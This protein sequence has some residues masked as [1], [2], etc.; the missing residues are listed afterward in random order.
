[1]FMR[2]I[3]DEWLAQG[4]Y[5]IGCQRTGEAIVID[6]ERDVDRYINLAAEHDLR[7][8]AVAETHIHADFLSGARELAEQVGARVYVSA[9]GG[10]DWRSGWLG[11][12]IDGGA[13]DAVELEDGQTF[14]IG[15]IE[16]RAVHT[17]G[18][19]PEHMSY[20]VTDLG[21]GASE[22]MGIATG[23]FVFV[24]DL[25]RPDLLETAA[26]HAGAKEPAARELAAS[27]RQFVK[28]PDYLQVWPAHGSGSACGKALGAVP[29]STVG[30]EKRFNPALA[31]V[32]DEQS[33][34]DFVLEGQ[35]E[36]PLYF[37]RMKRDNRDGVPILGPVPQPKPLNAHDLSQ[38]DGSTTAVLDTRPWDAFRGGHVTGALHAPLVAAF[39]TVAG[40]YVGEDEPIVLIVDPCDVDRAVRALI[41]IGLDNI[42]GFASIETHRAFASGGYRLATAQDI[43][44]QE[45]NRQIAEHA[46][47]VL[48]VRRAVEHAEGQIADSTNIAHTRLLARLDEL[49]QDRSSGAMPVMA[50]HCRSG[51]RSTY[52]VA[53][54]HRLGYSAVNVA[55]GMLAWEAMGGQV[56]TKTKARA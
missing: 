20:V 39:P 2:M 37:S 12:T 41:R 17:P 54:L 11:N 6:P 18:H 10:D 55:G 14:R 8:V 22:P 24:G 25:G 23:D 7:I 35:P 29:Q 4:A 33:F 1:M 5:L 30:Y 48:D 56:T 50:V 19:T 38:I 44:V 47:T 40:S 46:A 43:S 49:P 52:A 32:D 36:P 45:L 26:G 27:A 31:L 51:E 21:G 15:D 42:V 34:I 28:L 53:A 16:F 13:Y 9:M 3:Y